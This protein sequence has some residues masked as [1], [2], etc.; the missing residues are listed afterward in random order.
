[1][2]VSRRP[3]TKPGWNT[4]PYRVLSMAGVPGSVSYLQGF[5]VV[6]ALTDCDGTKYAQT[7]IVAQDYD[8]KGDIRFLKFDELGQVP[9]LVPGQRRRTRP[10]RSTP[11]ARAAGNLY[12][13][14]GEDPAY[15]YK[16]QTGKKV[17]KTS[18]TKMDYK[19]ARPQHGYPDRVGVP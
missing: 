7:W 8:N 4:T 5:C 16:W 2:S 13:W 19:G 11:T 17:S 3:P 14:C 6:P 9:R 15:R 12:V 10:D 1:M 18:G